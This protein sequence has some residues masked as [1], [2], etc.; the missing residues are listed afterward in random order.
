MNVVPA[1]TNALPA[2]GRPIGGMLF[3]IA[4]TLVET[5]LIE[6]TLLFPA[7]SS[8]NR[9]PPG[10]LGTHGRST[11][12]GLRL[13]LPVRHGSA[14]D[15]V[16]GSLPN[17]GYAA[18]GLEPFADVEGDRVLINP[19]AFP[20]F[21]RPRRWEVL[22]RPA[23][24]VA[25]RSD[26]GQTGCRSAGRIGRNPP[27]RRVCRWQDRD[28]DL[29][30]QRALAI[31]GHDAAYKPTLSPTPPPRWRSERPEGRWRWSEGCFAHPAGPD[32]EPVDWLVVYHH[33]RR[34]ISQH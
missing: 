18:N 2:S 32:H 20:L 12:G 8:A 22:C 34:P 10:L 21:R 6:G 24:A 15:A 16:P 28:K 1:A 11:C 3:R 5:W 17:C 9:C 19:E 7:G 26:R 25:G 29:A 14:A 33:G 4:A 13:S 30:Q 27:R 23:A 31:P